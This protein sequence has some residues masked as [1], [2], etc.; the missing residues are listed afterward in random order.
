MAIGIKEV[1]GEFRKIWELANELAEKET[2]QFGEHPYKMLQKTNVNGKVELTLQEVS[3]TQYKDEK[4]QEHILE[5]IGIL[6]QSQY[7]GEEEK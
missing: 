6:D 5:M 3:K 7:E 1:T 4:R 2:Q